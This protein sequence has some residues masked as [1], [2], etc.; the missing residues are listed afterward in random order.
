[1]RLRGGAAAQEEVPAAPP[2][3]SVSNQV[4]VVARQLWRYRAI[5]ET[6]AVPFIDSKFI[7]ISMT[8][9]CRTPW[10]PGKF[11]SAMFA[12]SH[13]FPTLMLCHS[14]GA[15]HPH[16]GRPRCAVSAAASVGLHAGREQLS[17]AAVFLILL[18]LIHSNHQK[19]FGPN[20]WGNHCYCLWGYVGPDP[21][22]TSNFAS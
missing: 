7:G 10:G 17:N 11:G 19:P 12:S 1:M 2:N 9:F 15:E 21:P 20:M 5:G 8:C 4:A 16:Q 6:Q 13:S 3:P 22:W 14:R 18:Q